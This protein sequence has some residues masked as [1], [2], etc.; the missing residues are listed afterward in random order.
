MT[1]TQ[2]ARLRSQLV[3]RIAYDNGGLVPI[4]LSLRNA[5]Y[6]EKL[7]L[8]HALGGTFA[9]APTG[10]DPLGQY[11]GALN[12]ITVRVNGVGDLYDCSGSM[13]AVISAIHNQY[14]YGF[15]QLLP[16]PPGAFAAAPGTAAYL[17]LWP[18]DIPIAF[19][20]ANK[21]APWGLVQL[22]TNSMDARLELRYNPQFGTQQASLAGVPVPGTA[23]YGG[24]GAVQPASSSGYT[25]VTQDYYDPIADPQSQPPLGFIHRWREIQQF[26]TSDGDVDF[27]LPASNLYTRLV[28]WYVQ[29]AAGALTTNGWVSPASPGVITRFQLRYGGN[30]APF[31][32]TAATILARMQR[33][34]SFALPV[35][36]Y[37]L[38]LMED[39]HT[40]RDW[41]DSSATTDLRLTVS[42]S[43]GAYAGGA[44]VKLGI[45]ELVPIAAPASGQVTPQGRTA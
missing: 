29:G 4:S 6:L 5:G 43:G 42:F 33:Q 26:V 13:A 15:G 2:Y 27:R 38:D 19:D 44:Y 3:G 18:I 41:I 22:A 34:Y 8:I 39:T 14:E 28:L 7:R 32:W 40:E 17:N 24:A 25:D 9:A 30:L 20:M 10:V 35:G 45:E 21:S 37:V 11:G 23:V 31:D 1:W 36:V 16:A 12:R